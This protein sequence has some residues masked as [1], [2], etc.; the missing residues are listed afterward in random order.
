MIGLVVS[1]LACGSG[2]GWF[3]FYAR[4]L[5]DMN[6]LA[7]FAPAQVVPVSDP[8]LTTATIAIPY[9]SIGNN[10]RAALSAAEIHGDDRGVLA[11][12]YLGFKDRAFRRATISS[13]ISRSMFCAPSK[14]LNREVAELRMA[15][16]LERRFSGQELFTIFAN[17]AWFGD[18]QVGVQAASQYFFQEDPNQLQIGEAALLVGLIRAPA[19]LSPFA[20][21]DR[22]LQR[23]NEVIDAMVASHAISAEEG[24]AAKARPLGVV[25]RKIGCIR[26]R[27]CSRKAVELRSIG[28]PRAAVPT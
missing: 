3:F 14:A 9:E 5:P 13:Q 1:A 18:G 20:H 16:R 6:G 22:A 25:A 28:Q 12:L 19:H 26:S 11:N 7:R 17:R 21:P 23:R 15:A 2:I 24:A 10:L 4:D 8:C 27:D